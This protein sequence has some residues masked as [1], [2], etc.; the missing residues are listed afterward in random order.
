MKTKML[1]NNKENIEEKT[2]LKKYREKFQMKI[3]KMFERKN[4]KEFCYKI[5]QKSPPYTPP[6][7]ILVYY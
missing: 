5:N 4:I 1:K 2:L 6:N 3:E 7:I